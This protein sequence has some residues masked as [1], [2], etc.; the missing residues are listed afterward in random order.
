[1]FPRMDVAQEGKHE[2]DDEE[3]DMQF[4]RTRVIQG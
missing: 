1:V 4:L 2:G 3:E